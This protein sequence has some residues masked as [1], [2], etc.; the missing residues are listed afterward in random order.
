M[1][2]LFS[3]IGAALGLASIP[4]LSQPNV[5]TAF[6]QTLQSSKQSSEL[7]PVWELFVNTQFFVVVI[8]NDTGDETKDFRFSVFEN[9]VDSKPYVL[10]SE[11]LDRL[12]NVQSGVAIKMSGAKLI[13]MLNPKL[14]ILIGLN[15]V[16]E[17]GFAM[18]SELVQWLRESI[19]PNDQLSQPG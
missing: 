13:Q 5:Q 9:P 16:D 1:K 17:G 8:R 18:P 7:M 14:G 12:E 3:A 19:Q 11:H 6:E 4:A 2:K 10:I 15:W